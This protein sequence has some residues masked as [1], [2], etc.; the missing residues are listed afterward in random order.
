MKKLLLLIIVLGGGYIAYG[1]ATAGSLSTVPDAVSV[2]K[3]PVQE[4]LQAHKTL[5]KDNF[6]ISKHARFSLRA[7]VLSRKSY[8]FDE[9]SQLSPVDLALGW[10]PMSSGAVLD[11]INISQSNR[12]YYY[13]Y[14]LP[15]PIPK[16]SI[17]KNSANM[18]MIPAN[19]RVADMLGRVKT[20]DLIRLSGYLVD[21]R[22]ED[23]WRWTS[24]RTRTDQGDGACELIWVEDLV[25]EDFT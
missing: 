5:Q 9:E 24:S 1:Y 3:D 15:P 12:F 8:S 14:K 17:V 18:H 13:R 21:V 6:T 20:G 25:I 19:E 4:S 2:T 11:K 10:G 16:S 23:G 22:R 7:V